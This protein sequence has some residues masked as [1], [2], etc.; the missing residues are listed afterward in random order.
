L[1][2]DTPQPHTSAIDLAGSCDSYELLLDQRLADLEGKLFIYWGDGTRAWVQRA[3]NQNKLIVE[4]HR[5]FRSA[6]SQGF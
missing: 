2:Q 3:D 4:L 1:A 6:N 5:Q